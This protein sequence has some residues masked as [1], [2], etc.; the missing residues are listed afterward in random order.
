MACIFESIEKHDTLNPKLWDSNN[1]LLQDVREKLLEIVEYFKKNLQVPLSIADIQL[2]GSNSSYNY[3]EHSDIDLHIIANF[4]AIE[5]EK[6]VLQALYNSERSSFNKDY[7]ISIHGIDVELY[8]QDI[9]STTVSNGIY[10]VLAD[11]WLKFPRKIDNIPEHDVSRELKKWKEKIQ[12][13]IDSKDYSKMEKALNDIY[14]VRK[15]SIDIDGEY[16]KGNQLFKEVRNLGLIDKLKDCMRAS[17]SKQLSMENLSTLTEASRMDLINKS[18]NSAKG[19]Q[20][21]KRRLKSRVANS[22]KEFNNIDMDKLFNED[23]L[24]VNV[25]VNGETDTYTVTITFGGFLEILRDE[26][27]RNGKFDTRSVTRA[28]LTGFNKDDVYIHCSCPDSYYRYSYWN[29]KNNVNSGAP[30]NIPA[31]ITNPNDS[32]GSTCKHTLL[33][34]SNNT[35]LLKVSSVIVNYVRY[36]ENHYQKMYA[37]IIYPAIYGKKYEKPVQLDIFDDE[38]KTTSTSDIDMANIEAR[39]RGQFKVG[40]KPRFVP[41]KDSDSQKTVFDDLDDEI[42]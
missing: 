10:S 22:V 11:K 1:H 39:K 31:P 3:T 14:F 23:I 40:N 20:R 24:T 15:N 41:T 17:K 7:D 19:M 30:Q 12:T 6:E 18:K 26:L 21:F 28:L 32:L 27:D 2:V 5:C 38:T 33:V 36:M 42:L 35:W 9:R 8:V 37:D 4:S 25:K 34:L 16:G 29:T 13:A